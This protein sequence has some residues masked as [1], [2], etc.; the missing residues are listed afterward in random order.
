[1]AMQL[2]RILVYKEIKDYIKILLLKI[3]NRTSNN[4]EMMFLEVSENYGGIKD[5]KYKMMNQS[6][7][8]L[9]IFFSK[10]LLKFYNRFKNICLNRSN[11]S[12]LI[13]FHTRTTK[14]LRINILLQIKILSN[15]WNNIL[16][17]IILSNL[18]NK[19]N[20][21]KIHSNSIKQKRNLSINRSKNKHTTLINRKLQ[22][23]NKNRIWMILY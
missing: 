23:N 11:H 7:N 8:L 12:N 21:I 3:C 19:P 13:T 1:M 6:L 18:S 14:Y 15:L 5:R 10:T 4:I 17:N 22:N 9:I 16:H 2:Q 20:F